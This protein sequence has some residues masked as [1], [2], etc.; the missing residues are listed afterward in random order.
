M[1]QKRQT[2]R[3]SAR[4]AT[5]PHHTYANGAGLARHATLALG[6]KPG[7]DLFSSGSVWKAADILLLGQHHICRTSRN[8]R[9]TN[10]Y[11]FS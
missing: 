6:L 2:L 5:V 3:H 10:V 7:T 1:K 11:P 4:N 9:R 8:R